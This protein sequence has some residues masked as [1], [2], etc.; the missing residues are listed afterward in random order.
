MQKQSTVVELVVAVV[1]GCNF[2]NRYGN[3]VKNLQ[4]KYINRIKWLGVCLKFVIMD[5]L[6]HI[7]FTSNSFNHLIQMRCCILQNDG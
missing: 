5:V 1:M 2:D 6:G 3:D 7:L 4:N